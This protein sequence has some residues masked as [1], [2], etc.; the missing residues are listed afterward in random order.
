RNQSLSHQAEYLTFPV[1]GRGHRR[2]VTGLFVPTFP[3][4]RRFAWPARHGG[5]LPVLFADAF[6]DRLSRPGI[7]RHDTGVRL[8]ADHRD[9]QLALQYGR[10]AHAEEGRWHV[11]ILARVTFPDRLA[12]GKID[13]KQ[14]SLR[15]EGVAAIGREQGSTPRSVVVPVR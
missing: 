8:A 14:F 9:Q 5:A 1:H 4:H 11:P 7:E 13:A 2:R 3:F 12:R 15:A 6:P 10:A